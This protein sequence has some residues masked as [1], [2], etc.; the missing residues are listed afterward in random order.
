MSN[1]E[2]FSNKLSKLRTEITKT[3]KQIRQ[4]QSDSP[5]FKSLESEENVRKQ[6]KISRINTKIQE[7][8][9]QILNIEL[10]ENT[11]IPELNSIKKLLNSELIHFT[12]VNTGNA[13]EKSIV[14]RI[15]NKI[16]EIT[17]QISQQKKRS[18]EH[19]IEFSKQTPDMSDNQ[20]EN[21]AGLP[22][23]TE[24]EKKLRLKEEER[25]MREFNIKRS[26]ITH[27]PS[28][29]KQSES[30]IASNPYKPLFSDTPEIPLNVDLSTFQKPPIQENPEP[31]KSS[32]GAISKH[33]IPNE[34]VILSTQTKPQTADPIRTNPI[35]QK[36]PT[37]HSTQFEIPPNFST[38]T[39]NKFA[40][41]VPTPQRAPQ[42]YTQN[43][44]RRANSNVTFA[45]ENPPQRQHPN[46]M[47]FA[48]NVQHSNLN[49][50]SND[51]FDSNRAVYEYPRQLPL[52]RQM[53]MRPIMARDS[54]LSFKSFRRIL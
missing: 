52:Q 34:N 6:K 51:S 32:T 7:T 54:Y 31:K 42:T 33:S 40:S 36:D 4:I 48:R 13:Y 46:E 29:I 10:T 45:D 49:D 47:R 38:P 41:Y 8:I 53:Y 22:Q 25:L 44:P 26:N 35:P 2:D 15:N 5:K 27:S 28:Q 17:K 43:I 3:T 37:I 21:N 23:E 1:I 11:P 30:M 20:I 9:D 39:S 24:D 12:I 14:E 50:T 18:L 16:N 19:F